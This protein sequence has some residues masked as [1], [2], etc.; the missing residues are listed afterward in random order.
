[1]ETQHSQMAGSPPCFATCH[2]DR[3]PNLFQGWMSPENVVNKQ[4]AADSVELI[5]TYIY[6]ERERERNHPKKGPFKKHKNNTPIL[7][8]TKL[9]RFIPSTPKICGLTEKQTGSTRT[10]G[11]HLVH[12]LLHLHQLILGIS[13]ESW[14]NSGRFF[15]RK[16]KVGVGRCFV[17]IPLSGWLQERNDKAH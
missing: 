12:L 17:C 3:I 8:A 15:F 7:H 6:R 14:T 1:M 10:P 9:P 2:C 16:P 13:A 11:L 4:V 5:Y